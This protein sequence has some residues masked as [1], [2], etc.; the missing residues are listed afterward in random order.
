MRH[1]TGAARGFT[2]LELVVAIA[3]VT[4]LAVAA[5]GPVTEMLAN[6]K[7][8]E[9]GATSHAAALLARSEAVKRNGRVRLTWDGDTLTVVDRVGLAS[10]DPGTV[11]R[12]LR[13]PQGVATAEPGQ[14]DFGAEG[15]TLPAGA[16]AQ[17][18]LREQSDPDCA[19]ADRRCPRVLIRSGGQALVCQDA[20]SAAQGCT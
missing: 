12:T 20:G 15:R 13:L 1:V 17:L 2:L 16:D 4:L 5:A 14:I 7:L 9:A 8:R 3:I 19:I 11:L 6:A 18:L 10:G